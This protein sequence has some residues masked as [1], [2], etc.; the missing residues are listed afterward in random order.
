MSSIW[1]TFGTQPVTREIMQI[2][3]HSVISQTIKYFD[4]SVLKNAK[5]FLSMYLPTFET[6]IF[7]GVAALKKPY[8]I[9]TIQNIFVLDP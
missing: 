4:N 9:K 7:W 3:N 5:A 8:A 2:P 1:I 6:K